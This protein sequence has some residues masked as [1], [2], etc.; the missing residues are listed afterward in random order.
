MKQSKSPRGQD[1][2]R[3][4]GQ[5]E[6]LTTP[7]IRSN[8]PKSNT[9]SALDL[10]APAG[11]LSRKQLSALDNLLIKHGRARFDQWRRAVDIAPATPNRRLSRRQAWQLLHHILTVNGGN[12]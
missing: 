9:L 6:L 2:G 4:E 7:I 5:S 12:E 11:D 1:A 10:Y 8:A 3:D